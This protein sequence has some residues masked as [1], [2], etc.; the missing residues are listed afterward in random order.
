MA[1][2]DCLRK[3]EKEKK[4]PQIRSFSV[5]IMIIVISSISAW[6]ADCRNFTEFS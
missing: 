4:T 2:E 5:I 3:K 1:Q 6:V